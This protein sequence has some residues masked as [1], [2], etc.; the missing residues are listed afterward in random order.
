MVF[1]E[2]PVNAHVYIDIAKE[3]NLFY[4][5]CLQ[6]CNRE[7]LGINLLLLEYRKIQGH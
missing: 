1:T 6:E 7:S 3:V 2:V 5:H 4:R